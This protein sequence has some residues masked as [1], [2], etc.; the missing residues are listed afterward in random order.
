MSELSGSLEQL[1]QCIALLISPGADTAALHMILNIRCAWYHDSPFGI[2]PIEHIEHPGRLCCITRCYGDLPVRDQFVDGRCTQVNPGP[3]LA[4]Q[5]LHDIWLARVAV[6]VVDEL[7]NGPAHVQPDT[8]TILEI[9]TQHAIGVTAFDR[10]QT[11]PE[12]VDER[13]REGRDCLRCRRDHPW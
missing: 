11:H 13:I 12:V 9:E 4:G 2:I 7:G 10:I 5:L 1:I 3:G 6:G 8:G